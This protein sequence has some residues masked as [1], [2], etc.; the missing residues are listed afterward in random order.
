MGTIPL[1]FKGILAPFDDDLR[2]DPSMTD[3]E[4]NWTAATMSTRCQC[5]TPVP[6]TLPSGKVICVHCGGPVRVLPPPPEERP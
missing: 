2:P 6:K 4:S 3:R 5:A 1:W